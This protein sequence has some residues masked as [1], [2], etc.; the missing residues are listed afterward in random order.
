MQTVGVS[1]ACGR[2]GDRRARTQSVLPL[3]FSGGGDTIL[4]ARRQSRSRASAPSCQIERRAPLW[5]EKCLWTPCSNPS[6]R[7][8]RPIARHSPACVRSSSP[9]RSCAAKSPRP[10]SAKRLSCAFSA[11]AS[12]RA[13]C[14]T[15]PP[16]RR[17]TLLPSFRAPRASA[18]FS[19][20]RTSTKSGTNPSITPSPSRRAPRRPRHR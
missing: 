8:S 13:G 3:P 15:Y 14:K 12:R 5:P 1:T 17:A 18:R 2:A 11:T 7:T 9:T 4:P 10:P 16:T 6:S 19:L 20:P